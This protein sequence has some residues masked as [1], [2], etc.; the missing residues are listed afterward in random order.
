MAVVVDV[1]GRGVFYESLV[2]VDESAWNGGVERGFGFL[3]FD[4]ADF[5]FFRNRSVVGNVPVEEI[6]VLQESDGVGSEPETVSVFVDRDCPHVV[7][8]IE[9][10]GRNL[11]RVFAHHEGERVGWHSVAEWGGGESRIEL[12]LR[13]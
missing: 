7:M 11:G 12:T 1:D 9:S 8:G 13:C 10:V 2:E 6:N 3:A 5:L 4:L